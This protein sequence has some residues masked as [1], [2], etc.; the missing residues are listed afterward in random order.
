MPAACE[1]SYLQPAALSSTLTRQAVEA[2]AA[3]HEPAAGDL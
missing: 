1:F 2:Q 3:L